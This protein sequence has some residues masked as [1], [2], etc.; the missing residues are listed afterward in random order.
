M[1]P[2]AAL[3][4]CA[5]AGVGA[6]A[7]PALTF[8]QD[9]TP[10][11]ATVGVLEDEAGLDLATCGDSEL[12]A[13]PAGAAPAAAYTIVSDESIARYRVQEVLAQVGETEAVGETRAFIGTIGFDEAGAPLACSRWDVDMRTLQS[14]SARRDNY[15]YGNTLETE[16]FPLSTFVLR[17]VE[18]LD[19]PLPEGEETT[20]TLLGDLTVKDTT[21][22]V[23]W[24]ATATR[25]G[26]TLSGTAFT[27]FEMADFNI[28]P[29]MVPVVL[30]L[31]ETVRLEIELSAA[32]AEQAG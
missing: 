11:P 24:E 19:G 13:L 12:G 1:R 25:D 32:P 16:R 10:T 3:L 26:D 22:P 4:L 9:A 17:G 15:L 7:V 29:P 31:D 27:E 18:G 23:A 28:T 20:F 14:D 21:R 5:V 6:G 2:A 8:A 30:S